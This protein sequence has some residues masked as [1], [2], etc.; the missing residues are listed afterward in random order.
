MIRAAFLFANLFFAQQGLTAATLQGT[1]SDINLN[2]LEELVRES[3][4]QDLLD[5]VDD[6]KILHEKVVTLREGSFVDEAAALEKRIYRK[7]EKI[8]QEATRPD[9]DEASVES[10]Y[11]SR[12]ERRKSMKEYA[13]K[14]RMDA[15][16]FDESLA[17]DEKMRY[18]E[19][20]KHYMKDAMRH[21]GR[22]DDVRDIHDRHKDLLTHRE[23]DF[24]KRLD[25]AG[26]SPD[27]ETK[28][29]AKFEDYLALEREVMDSRMQ[30]RSKEA[31]AAHRK[32]S[33]D[34]RDIAREEMKQRRQEEKE[35]MNVARQMRKDIDNIIREKM[36]ETNFA[37]TEL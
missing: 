7:M 1:D 3:N 12:K 16:D 19:R 11:M 34:E 2:Q 18:K 23:Q 37:G 24:K 28:L 25:K 22:Y 5:E 32:K 36:M 10:D 14:H 4:K 26:F 13:R 15:F 8:Q 20:Y 17:E 31:R 33:K 6:L 9:E 21:D 30:D 35:K 27:E 29:I